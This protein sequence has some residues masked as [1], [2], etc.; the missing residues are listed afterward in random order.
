MPYL[1]GKAVEDVFKKTLAKDQPGKSQYTLAADPLQINRYEVCGLLAEPKT[2]EVKNAQGNPL[3]LKATAAM[4]SLP[5]RSIL[6][7]MRQPALP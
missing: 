7:S 1:D 5:N 3:P 6:R 2:V 4:K